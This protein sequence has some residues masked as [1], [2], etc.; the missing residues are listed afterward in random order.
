MRF[1]YNIALGGT[2]QSCPPF[3]SMNEC[4]LS[5]PYHI[6]IQATRVSF[7]LLSCPTPCLFFSWGLLCI[8]FFFAFELWNSLTQDP[9]KLMRISPLVLRVFGPSPIPPSNL[10]FKPM[11]AGRF[12]Q[13]NLKQWLKHEVIPSSHLPIAVWL[14]YSQ[15]L[16]WAHL[17]FVL[18]P[19]LLLTSGGRRMSH[20]ALILP[21]TCLMRS[22]VILIPV[23]ISN[24]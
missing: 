6:V 4:V 19:K 14:F 21:S 11:L 16:S 7:L 22:M 9:L 18:I 8:E 15:L 20:D 12:S 10:L 17:P 1:H 23:L 3:Y 24:G 2:S 13:D 5:Y